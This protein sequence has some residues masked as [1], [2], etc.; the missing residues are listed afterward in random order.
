VV[1]GD[2]VA[3]RDGVAGPERERV[4]VGREKGRVEGR[5]EATSAIPVARRLAGIGAGLAAVGLLLLLRGQ[6]GLA[7]VLYGSGPLASVPRW[8]SQLTGVVP[9]SLAELF[10]VAVLGRQVLGVARGLRAAPR[11]LQR[12]APTLLLR[13]ALRLGQDVGVLVALFALLWGGQYARPGLEARLGL[14]DPGTVELSELEGLARMAVEEANRYYR[15][16][17]GSDDA[18]RPTP[19][20][21]GDELRPQLDAAWSTVVLRH[22]LPE[23]AAQPH[24][25][26]KGF[27]LTPLMHPFGVAGMYFPFTGEALLLSDLPGVLFPK[28]KAHEMAHQRGFA[29]ESDANALAFLV[30]READDP[31]IRYSAYVFLQNQ[32]LGTMVPLDPE[33]ARAV[34]EERAPGVVRDLE[35]RTRYWAT[36]TGWT[37]WVGFSLND[38]MLRAHGVPEGVASYQGS[39]R[40]FVALARAQGPDGLRPPPRGAISPHSRRSPTA[41]PS[42]SSAGFLNWSGEWGRL[43]GFRLGSSTPN[44]TPRPPG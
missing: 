43:E 41:I 36:A 9:V 39:V 37:R 26:S 22:G 30:A 10:V 6:P 40:V 11:P 28:E 44:Q 16:I 27:L 13:G 42:T 23:R 7:E 3:G 34:M 24:G 12:A 31:R 19:R 29:S 38:L 2:E 14:A 33:R 35:D 21:G 1:P 4:C 5:D 8:L 18:G 15:E 20:A 17:H 32:L 25:P